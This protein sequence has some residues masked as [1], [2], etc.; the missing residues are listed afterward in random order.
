MIADIL[1]TLVGRESTRTRIMYGAFLSFS[2]ANDFL[3][4]LIERDLV[5][6][7]RRTR[8]YAITARGRDLLDRAESMSNLVAIAPFDKVGANF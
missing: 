8:H 2:Q 7:D 3:Q 4:Y 5:T 6:F 1:Q